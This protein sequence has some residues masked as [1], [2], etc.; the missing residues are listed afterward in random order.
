MVIMDI[1]SNVH[2]LSIFPSRMILRYN[3]KIEGGG[4]DSIEGKIEK[5]IQ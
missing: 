4:G 2:H 3:Y 5:E 1:L